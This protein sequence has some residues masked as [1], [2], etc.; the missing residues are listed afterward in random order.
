[1]LEEIH[2]I[3]RSEIEDAARVYGKDLAALPEA[4]LTH[5]RGGRLAIDFTY[6]VV[7]INRRMA[8]RLRRAEPEAMAP[9]FLVA[10]ELFR[11]KAV[12]L[13][14]VASSAGELLAAWDAVGPGGMAEPVPTSGA[15]EPALGL[16]IFAARH[17]QHHDGQLTYLQ[18]L[19]G[20]GANH[21]AD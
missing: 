3:V 16:A 21:W 20:D 7:L 12:A 14:E 17:M 2:G 11:S 6:E 18:S 10:P 13:D 1:M 15:P 4:E 19:L 9:G 5:D 8:A